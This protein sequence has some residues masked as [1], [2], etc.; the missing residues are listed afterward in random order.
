MIRLKYIIYVQ[1]VLIVLFLLLFLFKWSDDSGGRDQYKS[2][3][4]KIDGKL[5]EINSSIDSIRNLRIDA[6]IRYVDKVGKIYSLDID[7]LDREIRSRAK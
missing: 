3:L 4:I 6:S 1:S 5:D 2:K 7:D